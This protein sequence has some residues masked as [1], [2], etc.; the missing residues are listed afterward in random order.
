MLFF[1]TLSVGLVSW[2]S[3]DRLILLHYFIEK[4]DF[5]LIHSQIWKCNTLYSWLLEWNKEVTDMGYFFTNYWISRIKI[6]GSVSVLPVCV[7]IYLGR[8][9][10]VMP[11]MPLQY[12][13]K[14]ITILFVHNVS[15]THDGV[16][17]TN[18]TSRH[19]C[20]REWNLWP[21]SIWGFVLGWDSFMLNDNFI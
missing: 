19:S 7:S 1:V 6:H 13:Y 21:Q 11:S 3:N 10:T 2:I 4:L 18:K 14:C 5:I 17:R 12:R 9:G 8:W 15:I 16:V 20:P